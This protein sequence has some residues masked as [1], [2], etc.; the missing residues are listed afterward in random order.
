M[1]D[2]GKFRAK[3]GLSVQDL[4][5]AVGVHRNTI[6]SLENNLKRARLDTIGKLAKALNCSVDDLLFLK[7]QP[8]KE[9]SPKAMALALAS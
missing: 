4:A 2:L 3:A 1:N 7:D 9:K 8:L 5:D 6:Y